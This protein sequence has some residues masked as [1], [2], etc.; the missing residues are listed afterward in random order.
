MTG[1]IKTT[2]DSLQSL[3]SPQ[4]RS[5]SN[6]REQEIRAPEA[7]TPRADSVELTDKARQLLQLEDKLAQFPA[8]DS[9]RV[10]AVRQAIADGSYRVDA[11][12]IAERM[13]ANEAQQKKLE[14]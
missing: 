8:V 1:D 13:L 7:G 14:P 3:Y 11:D 5:V 6:G 10:D 9:Q 2:P 12:L 4:D